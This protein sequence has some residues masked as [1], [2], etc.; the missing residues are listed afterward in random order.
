MLAPVDTEIFQE[1]LQV[2]EGSLPKELNGVL[3]RTG[4]NEPFKPWGGYHLCEPA[5]HIRSCLR[6]PNSA[7][8][9]FQLSLPGFWGAWMRLPNSPADLCSA[10]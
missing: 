9:M 5:C 6:I 4:P 1:D 2:V 7:I 3:L 8:A 10:V